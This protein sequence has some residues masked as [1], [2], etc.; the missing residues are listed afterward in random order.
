MDDRK[1][2]NKEADFF[3]V[4]GKIVRRAIMD[5]ILGSPGIWMVTMGMMTAGA[6]GSPR[7]GAGAEKPNIV[8]FLTDD[9]DQVS[10]RPTTKFV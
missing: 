2:E 4:S 7:S 8:W 9:Q 6:V 5:I 10:L 3:F 1:F